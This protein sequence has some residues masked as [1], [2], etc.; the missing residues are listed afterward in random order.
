[1]VDTGG[2]VTADHWSR[3]WPPLKLAP[4]EIGAI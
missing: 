3:D 2:E 1:M 4:S